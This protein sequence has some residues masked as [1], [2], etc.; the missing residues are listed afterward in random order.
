MNMLFG[1]I[2]IS[3]INKYIFIFFSL[4][5]ILTLL[6]GCTFWEVLTKIY[7][8]QDPS[9][10]D[11]DSDS[12]FVNPPDPGE[13]GSFESA[14]SEGYLEDEPISESPSDPGVPITDL[15][16]NEEELPKKPV[17]FVN[18][19]TFDATVRAATYTPLGALEP[20]IPPPSASTVSTA[21]PPSG[22]W[23]NTSR[24]ITVPLG[25]Y[26]W[27]IDWEEGDVDEDGS[28]DY[29]HY[30]TEEPTLLDYD[31]SDELEFA[32]EVAIS[33]PPDMAPIYE[34]KC[35]MDDE[36]VN[37]YGKSTF[38]RT[39]IR[40]VN[41]EPVY[42]MDLQA[43]ADI[44]QQAPPDGIRISVSGPAT[45]W[46]GWK[47]LQSG[48][49]IEATTSDPYT[50][51][52]VQIFGDQTIGYATVYF[53]GNVVWAGDTSECVIDPNENNGLGWY[54]IYVE[55]LCFP[56]GTHTLRVEAGSPE[57][58][59]GGWQGGV[60]VQLFGFRR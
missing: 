20:Q 25:S 59:A 46:Y 6:S 19:G 5:L 41:H 43:L 29:Y 56:P 42:E 52:G 16:T 13:V 7:H 38:V 12:Q 39:L 49:W 36:E 53:D 40:N 30:Y 57:P 4:F 44:N 31:D 22:T 51:M 34:G 2:K 48:A 45:D 11:L 58:D 32:Q 27:C 37:C 60:P 8:G 55:V 23:P 47:I 33:A 1:G 26:T 10:D 17:G 9:I 14:Q 50:A 28:F 15:E 18:Y 21:K 35:G 3:R 24:F 54:G